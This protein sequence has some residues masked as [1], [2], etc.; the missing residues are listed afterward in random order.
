MLFADSVIPVKVASAQLGD[1]PEY[2]ALPEL[3]R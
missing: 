1:M 2:P 3:G